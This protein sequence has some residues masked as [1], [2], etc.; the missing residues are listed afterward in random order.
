M[1]R[2]FFSSYT[3]TASLPCNLYNGWVDFLIHPKVQTLT[4]NDDRMLEWGPAAPPIK[5]KFVCN[6]PSF[7]VVIC[8]V[9]QYIKNLKT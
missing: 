4:H 2:E 7:I 6:N 9:E 8:Q 3:S 5:F 1:T